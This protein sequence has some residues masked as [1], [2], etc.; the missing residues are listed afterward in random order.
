V[1]AS[2]SQNKK[3]LAGIAHQQAPSRNNQ[4]FLPWPLAMTTEKRSSF[5]DQ[6]IAEK[7]QQ[8]DFSETGLSLKFALGSVSITASSFPPLYGVV[9]TVLSRTQ[10]FRVEF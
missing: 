7:Y 5:L 1:L 2:Q 4:R 10:Q 3:Y 8:L 9:R 6:V